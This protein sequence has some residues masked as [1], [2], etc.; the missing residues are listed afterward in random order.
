MT[1]N[2]A[3]GVEVIP[4]DHTLIVSTEE[5]VIIRCTYCG[6]IKDMM[7]F[8][9]TMPISY[10]PSGLRWCHCHDDH[11]APSDGGDI[12]RVLAEINVG[13]SQCNDFQGVRE[14]IVGIALR[15]AAR[16][17]GKA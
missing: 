9:Q 7:C 5:A 10:A 16:R 17:S 4:H 1:V 8:L 15:E 12:Q 2:P 11:N 13:L 14:L 6:H 3:I